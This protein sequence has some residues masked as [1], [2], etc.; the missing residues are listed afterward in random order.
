MRLSWKLC[1]LIS[2]LLFGT[3]ACGE[4]IEEEPTGGEVVVQNNLEDHMSD[5]VLVINDLYEE[6]GLAFGFT[7]DKGWHWVRRANAVFP[8]ALDA[9][10]LPH[11]QVAGEDLFDSFDAGGAMGG[12]AITFSATGRANTGFGAAFQTAPLFS[13]TPA[14]T[15]F[16]AETA[17]SVDFPAQVGL[18]G[19]GYSCDLTA[20]CDFAARACGLASQFGESCEPGVVNECYAAV[21]SVQIPPELGPFIC[22]VIAFLDCILAYGEAALA[23]DAASASCSIPIPGFNA[24]FDVDDGPDGPD[25]NN[26]NNFGSNN[27]DSNNFEFNNSPGF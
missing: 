12:G 11:A 8:E 14:T 6:P 19:S 7:Q 2:A 21:Y 25:F 22:A 4:V 15:N 18:G 27:F 5:P 3:L 13:A 24:D 1:A 20:I 26:S 10:A 9:A 23:G 17:P 16:S